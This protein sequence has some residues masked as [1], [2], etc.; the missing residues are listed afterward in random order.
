[1]LSG[2]DPTSSLLDILPLLAFNFGPAVAAKTGAAKLPSCNDA[3]N[4]RNRFFQQLPGLT[5]VASQLNVPTN[6]IVGLSSYESGWLDN[7]NFALHNLWGL[8]NAGGNNL[9]FSSFQAGNTYFVNNVGPY[10]QG[11]Q[12]LSAFFS[13]LKN[14]GYNSANPAYWTT[15]QNRISKIPMWEAACGVK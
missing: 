11:A 14:E 12:R 1:M 4:N 5:S 6:F 3:K 8:T 7:H 2:F 10:I 15:L 9:N 13:G